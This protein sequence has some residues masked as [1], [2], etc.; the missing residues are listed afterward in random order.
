MSFRLTRSGWLHGARVTSLSKMTFW[1]T[2]R[3]ASSKITP[4]V[5]LEFRTSSVRWVAHVGLWNED[6]FSQSADRS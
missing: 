5:P 3:F 2:M 4:D 6:S 1:L